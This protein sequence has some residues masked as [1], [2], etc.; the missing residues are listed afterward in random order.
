MDNE[1]THY[2]VKGMK[3]GVRRTPEQLG[4]R[5]SATSKNARERSDY[6]KG[7]IETEK[8]S[9]SKSSEKKVSK[10]KKQ[11][12]KAVSKGKNVS[13]AKS[14][15]AYAKDENNFTQKN[16]DRIAA[17]GAKHKEIAH[18]SVKGLSSLAGSAGLILGSASQGLSANSALVT[19]L[20]AKV[21]AAGITSAAGVAYNTGLMAGVATGAA[22]LAGAG[23]LAGGGYAA[24]QHVRNTRAIDRESKKR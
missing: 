17:K 9:I 1:L 19:A 15:Y 23:L 3:W 20:T 18:M 12:D 14:K 6:A 16:L 13:A 24:Y 5:V 22:W 10:A 7:R 8:R 4:Y 2:G 21:N 11:Y